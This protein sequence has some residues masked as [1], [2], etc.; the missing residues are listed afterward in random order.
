MQALAWQHE[1]LGE[2]TVVVN[3]ADDAA[4]RTMITATSIAGLT[5]TTGGVNLSDDP[6]SDP[7]IW[8]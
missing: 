8:S 3:D 4:L 2:R 5:A 1:V 6:L 7:T